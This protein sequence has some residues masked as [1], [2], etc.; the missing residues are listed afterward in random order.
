M[1]APAPQDRRRFAYRYAGE[2]WMSDVMHGP[3][4]NYNGL[5]QIVRQVP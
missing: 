4:V 3:A 2:L 5:P 1:Q